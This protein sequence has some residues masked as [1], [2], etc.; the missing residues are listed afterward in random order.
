MWDRLKR[1]LLPLRNAVRVLFRGSALGK[2][3]LAQQARQAG[4][5]PAEGQSR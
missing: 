4:T 3:Q 1:P 2:K 5:G